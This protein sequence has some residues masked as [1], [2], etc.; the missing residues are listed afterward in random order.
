MVDRLNSL[1]VGK[2]V[3]LKALSKAVKKVLRKD[4]KTQK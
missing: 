2:K 3:K 1:K 4:W